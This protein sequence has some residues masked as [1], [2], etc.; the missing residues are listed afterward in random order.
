MAWYKFEMGDNFI[1]SAK[2]SDQWLDEF[3][4]WM[5]GTFDGRMFRINNRGGIE[6]PVPPAIIDYL[7]EYW[8]ENVKVMEQD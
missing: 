5:E 2:E 8:H 3:N 4:Q 6:S 7:F 1:G